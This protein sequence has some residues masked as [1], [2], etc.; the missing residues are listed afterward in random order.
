MKTISFS[1][2]QTVEL[3]LFKEKTDTSKEYKVIDET[4]MVDATIDRVWEVL[5]KQFASVSDWASSVAHT[6]ARDSVGVNGSICTTR[7]CEINGFGEIA[8]KLL[9]YSD[10]EHEFAY[11]I[12]E[13]MPKMVKYATNSWKAIEFPNGKCA[14][15]SQMKVKTNGMMGYLMS[16][17]MVK[18]FRKS[19]IELMEDFKYYVEN[20][21]PHPRK[22]SAIA[23]LKN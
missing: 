10:E 19:L 9:Y 2:P 17:M 11:V 21:K 14:V 12:I 18:N 22:I 23:K 20:R 3:P 16:G 8:E 13:G 15:R 5:G 6:E 1:S 4:I 7:G